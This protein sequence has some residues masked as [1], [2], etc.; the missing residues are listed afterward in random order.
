MGSEGFDMKKLFY[1]FIAIMLIE[2]IIL[3]D[4]DKLISTLLTLPGLV[5][6][7]SVHEFSHAK[8][9]DKYRRSYTG[10]TR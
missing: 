6:A 8:A 7:I 4:K 5:L 10:K 3:W 2:G 1:I 9:S